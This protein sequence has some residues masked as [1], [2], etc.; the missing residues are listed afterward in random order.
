MNDC[1]GVS[2][3]PRNF[4]TKEERV[5]MLK[6]YKKTLEQEAKGVGERIRDLEKNN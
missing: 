1:C 2:C 3:A 4:F 5:E 6:E